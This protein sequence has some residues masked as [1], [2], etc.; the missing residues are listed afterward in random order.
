MRYLGLPA[1]KARAGSC[2]DRD[3]SRQDHDANLWPELGWSGVGESRIFSSHWR[4]HEFGTGGGS[5]HARAFGQSCVRS[6]CAR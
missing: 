2:C 1:Q 5:I 6:L 3:R 4:S